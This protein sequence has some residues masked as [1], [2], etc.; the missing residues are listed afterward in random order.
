MIP[1]L[2]SGVISGDEVLSELPSRRPGTMNNSIKAPYQMVHVELGK[3]AKDPILQGTD[4]VRLVGVGGDQDRRNRVTL[5]SKASVEF[6]TG[7]RRHMDVS[8]Q[9]VGFR[10]MPRNKEFVCRREGS[11][12]VV[13]RPQK[14][15]HRFAKESIII[16]NGDKGCL[17][18]IGHQKLSKNVRAAEDRC[19]KE[20]GNPQTC[21]RSN[22]SARK[23]WF[24]PAHGVCR[25]ETDADADACKPWF[26]VLCSGETSSVFLQARDQLT[27]RTFSTCVRQT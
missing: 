26:T 17:R 24:M 9:A 7:N 16:D 8:D 23:F 4:A 25:N 15:L 2:L 22:G 12:A 3:I 21:R 20:R 10:E 1:N 19:P 18:H 14:P 6:K 11:D 5:I 27:R 13:E